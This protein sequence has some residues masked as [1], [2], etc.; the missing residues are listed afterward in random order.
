MKALI[1]AGVAMATLLCMAV[2]AVADAGDRRAEAKQ[3][4]LRPADIP[5][6]DDNPYTVE[7][8]TLGWTLFFDPRLSGSGV[9]SCATCHNPSLGWGDGLATGIGHMGAR[10]KRRS[11]TVMNLA[12]AELLMWD[13]RADSLEDQALGPMKNP[14]EMNMMPDQ[15]VKILA[16]MPEYQALFDAAFPGE[17]ITQAAITRAL[18]TYQ[19]T[20]VSGIAPFDR[21][22]AGDEQAI[23]EPAK[24]GFD[25]FTGKAN[26][27]ECHS[28]WNFTDQ[29]FYDI[30]LPDADPGR[31]AILPLPSMRHAFKTPTLR[32]VTRRSP[33]MHDGSVKTLADVVRHYDTGFVQRDSLSASMKRLNLTDQEVAD[34]VAFMETLTAP[35]QPVTIPVLPVAPH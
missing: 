32:D 25:L 6:P 10:L 19:R 8:A 27:A 18:A 28:G 35:P 33:Y 31:G 24:R 29:G 13:G 20:I 21:W 17:G 34:L 23:G 9:I 3:A 16:G 4:F 30:G 5:F 2:P 22:I 26:C 1:V 11:P 12:W 14:D 7:K 15:A